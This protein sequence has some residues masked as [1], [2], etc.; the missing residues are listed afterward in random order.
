MKFKVK[1][2]GNAEIPFEDKDSALRS[3]KENASKLQKV[4][5]VHGTNDGY[6]WEQ[7]ALIYPSGQVQEGTGGFGFFKNLPVGRL[8]R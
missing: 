1:L 5:S 2:P 3:A 8:R 4:I 7:I 6:E